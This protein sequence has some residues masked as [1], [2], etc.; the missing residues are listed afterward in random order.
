MWVVTDGLRVA[1]NAVALYQVGVRGSSLEG[2]I[3]FEIQ[4]SRRLVLAALSARTFESRRSLIEQSRAADLG[5]ER[6]QNQFQLLPITPVLRTRAREFARAWTDYLEIRDTEAEL[7]FGN[8]SDSAFEMDLKDGDPQF[9]LA[10]ETVRQIKM[11]LDQYSMN[12]EAE[13]RWGCYRAGVEL[14]VLTIGVLLA[15]LALSRNRQQRKALDAMRMLNE[16]LRKASIAAEAANRLKSEFLANMSHEIRTPMNGILGMTGL[17]L[18]TDLTA[19]QRDCLQTSQDCAVS[20]LAIINEILDFSKIEAGKLDLSETEFELR[21]TVADAVKTLALKA[22][23]K[24]LELILQIEPGTPDIFIADANRLRQILSNLVGNAV[25]FT[26]EGEI[27]VRASLEESPG[28]EPRL[29]FIVQDSGIGIPAD[30][31]ANIFEAFVQADGST[32]RNYGGTG[33]GLSICARLTQLMGGR[34][35]VESSPGQGSRFHFTI[36]ARVGDQTRRGLSATLDA[37]AG[38][39]ALVVDDNRTNRILIEQ[40]L[41]RWKM[42]PT[43]VDGARAALDALAEAFTA[44][45]PFSLLLLDSQMPYM[46]GF[47][48]ARHIREDPRFALTTIMMLTSADQ[49][50]DNARCRELGIAYYLCKPITPEDLLG[51]IL[52]TLPP[53]KPA[54]EDLFTGQIVN[55]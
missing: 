41:L 21:R 51:T 25:K 4:E 16:Q 7:I 49:L 28:T 45:R 36:L 37:L 43:S 32:T 8:R 11:A 35:W 23:Q 14:L 30:R 19:D 29:H 5:A 20:L 34:I 1:N 38:M 44:G 24:Q 55:A 40:Q 17:V 18:D 26:K 47:T 22:H 27:V 54:G 6:L 9:H 50:G 3:E 53:Q 33:L 31:Q 12:Q 46:D 13:V 39:H 48:L 10:Y 52:K 42:Q 2:D 15:L